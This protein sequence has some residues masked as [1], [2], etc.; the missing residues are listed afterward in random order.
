MLPGQQLEHCGGHLGGVSYN[1]YLTLQ[2]CYN[3]VGG[4]N[5]SYYVNLVSLSYFLKGFSQ[6]LLFN[7][8]VLVV[9]F[10]VSAVLVC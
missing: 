4:E 5:T 3:T 9:M 8:Q 2:D 7:N 10:L 1:Y 6:L